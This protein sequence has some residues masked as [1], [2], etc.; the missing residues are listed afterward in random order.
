MN[1][2]LP[3]SLEEGA[4]YYHNFDQFDV[5]F[6]TGDSYYDHPLSGVAVLTRLLDVKGYKVGIVAQPETD[7]DFSKCGKPKYFFC[8]TSGLLDSML[9]N[10]TPMLRKRENV[11]VPERALIT[12]TAKVKQLFKRSITVLGGVE[13]TI[14]RFTHFDYKENNLRRGIL[15][16]S[17]AEILLFGNA[18]RS[19]LE[20]I[21]KFKELDC[22]EEDFE[23][24]KEKLDLLHIDG[25]AY[26]IKKEEI[27]PQAI[28]LPSYEECLKSKDSFNIIA[29]TIFLHPEEAFVEPCGLGLVQHNKAGDQ[30]TEEEMDFIYELPFTRTLHPKMKNF[31]FNQKM[32]AGLKNSVILGRGCWG[33]CTFCVIPLVQGKNVAK[34]STE[35]IVSEIERLYNDGERLINDLTLPTLNM[36]GSYCD[37]YAVTQ[38]KFSAIVDKDVVVMKKDKPCSQKCVGCSHRIIRDDLIP[39]L[40][41]VEKLNVRCNTKLELRSAIRHDIILKQKKLF[42]EIMKFVMRLKIAPEHVR[43]EILRQMNKSNR[44]AFLDFL[45]EYELVN[46]E[47]STHKNLVPYFV[48]AHPGCT[49]DDMY[50]L[51]KFCVEH[52]LFVNLTQV[53]TPT[54]GTIATSIYYTGRNPLTNE[55]VY[56]ARTFRERKEQKEI[57]FSPYQDTDDESG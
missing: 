10:Y 26:R 14:R 46:K 21:R 1:L 18:E 2:F 11:L 45:K 24:V 43:D 6:I 12:Y 53:F 17:K 25:A 44:K 9:A 23:N 30:L 16:D 55:E 33:G 36:Y 22:I 19:L 41:E 27:N 42:R 48:A 5:I 37:L 4:E 56:V 40:H 35:S 8:I 54:P 57:L 15:N 28:L 34:R 38:K 47:Q 50:E 3:V 49:I 13:A 20:L 39:L 51:K 7:A 29:K 32:I 31:D 52:K